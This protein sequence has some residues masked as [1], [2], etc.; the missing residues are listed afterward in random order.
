MRIKKIAL[1]T[2]VA[3]MLSVVGCAEK[4]DSS[5]A[6][7]K[8]TQAQED[9]T[10]KIEEDTTEMATEHI[11]PVET[12][13]ATL[14]SQLTVNKTVG[15]ANGSNTIKFPLADLIEDGDRVTSFTFTIYSDNGINIGDFKGGCGI[16]VDS[17]CAAATDKG[18]Y[19][20][21]DFT[22]PTQ[23]TYGEITWIVPEELRDHI[24]AA[25]EVLFG[26]W[27]GNCESIRLENVV[28]QFERK[29]EVP[30]DGMGV[31][32]VGQSVNYSDAD[33]TVH[34]PLDFIPEGT[35]PEVV[36]FN[37]SSG[38]G[39]GKYT[40]A[41][42]IN[43]SAGY[44]QSGDTAV[45]TESSE[46]ELTWFVPEAA[47]AY[48]AQDNELVLGYW[49][50]KQPSVTVNTVSVKYSQGEGYTGKMPPSASKKQETTTTASVEAENGGFRMA[51]EIVA[52]IKVG[53]NLGNTLESYKTSKTGLD[54][55]T[56][57]ENPK[58]TKEIIKNVKDSG[59]NAIRIPVT[60]AEHMNETTIQNE[61]LD[62]VQEV[63][64]YAYDEGMFVILNMHHDDYI[65][66]K[67]QPDTYNG[68]SMRLQN[69]WEQISA[70]FADYGDR[71]LFE[72]MNEPRTVGSSME[73]MG[74]TKEER[75]IVNQYA[76]VFVDTVRASG[77]NNDKRTLIVPTYAASAESVALNEM[78]IPSG[79][80]II[81][82]VH[83]YAPWKFSDG[84]ETA[85]T[86]SGRSEIDAKFAELKQKF[87]SKGIPVL[88]DECGCVNSASEATRCDYYRYYISSAKA[89][90]LKCFIW[91]NGKLD[92][93]SSFGIFNRSALT[94][95]TA[96]LN[97]IMDG[98]R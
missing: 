68:N 30:V 4:K 92:G 20:S 53:W 72:G 80:N 49:W 46:L 86:D 54:T 5:R 50:S 35:L 17:D 11:S 3:M 67:P 83:Y 7:E 70:R 76:Q 18:W 8:E 57:W 60:W 61:W 42:G 78:V 91:D 75:S 59:F 89:N 52:Q 74:G 82:S 16:S 14:G 38:G 13:S 44:Y 28:C 21:S 39:F 71:L 12:V 94:W 62:R 69:I 36:T 97:A 93:D 24:H 43:S 55:E 85:F 10:A 51:D 6:K 31:C 41:Y 64:D 27:W 65:W 23:G 37:V 1:V 95:N 33:N 47:K 84:T 15:R 79:R 98:A 90:G 77:G 73:W 32:E 48:I 40:G 45:F 88:I 9:T 56:G 22:A 58:T 26:Y 81:L 96:I 25:G 29:R 63:V 34:I 2:A 87:I 19:Q 66:F